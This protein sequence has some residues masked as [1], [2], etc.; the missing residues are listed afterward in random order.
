MRPRCALRVELWARRP[1]RWATH[2]P[3]RVTHQPPRAPSTSRTA[4]GEL[5]KRV[6]RRTSRHVGTRTCAPRR[7]AR[8][9]ARPATPARRDG[10]PPPTASPHP[11][12][13][14]CHRPCKRLQACG[15]VRVAA[16]GRSPGR[17]GA[18]GVPVGWAR[19]YVFKGRQSFPPYPPMRLE[20]QPGQMGRGRAH[21]PHD[22]NGQ[23]QRTAHG[24]PHW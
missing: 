14:A 16:R 20:G 11:P 4:P 23:G 19:G 18:P 13:R 3:R 15:E 2:T 22:P 6:P 17:G 12:V 8:P 10:E 7:T 21:S 24:I 1:G 5:G 9:A